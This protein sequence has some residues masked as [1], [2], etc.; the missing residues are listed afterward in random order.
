M[1]IQHIALAIS[2]ANFALTWG[3]ALY[4]YLANKNK[5]TN[6][7]ITK[8]EEQMGEKIQQLDDDVEG[9]LVEY[10]EK[11]ARL[12]EGAEHGPTRHDLGLLHE[13][14][15]GVNAQVS[16]FSGQ[17]SGIDATLRQIMDRIM[18]KGLS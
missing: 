7:R 11:I 6:E 17:L 16:T 10:G 9:R 3:V 14:I 4:M 8:L 15:N 1:E 18:A 5:V 2:V 12:E 13:K